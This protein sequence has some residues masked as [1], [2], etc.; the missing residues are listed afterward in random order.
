MNKQTRQDIIDLTIT[1][2]ESISKSL[3][4]Q[5]HEYDF[6]VTNKQAKELEK[7]YLEY[8]KLFIE[9]TKS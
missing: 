2:I 4:A 9:I 1:S 7:I 6:P 5:I 3:I 8:H